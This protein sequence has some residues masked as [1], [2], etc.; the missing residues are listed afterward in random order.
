MYLIIATIDQIWLFLCISQ[1]EN[2]ITVLTNATNS[3][4]LENNEELGTIRIT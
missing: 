3:Q 2:D 1:N 4:I